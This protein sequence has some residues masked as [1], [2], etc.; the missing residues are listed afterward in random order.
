MDHSDFSIWQLPPYD[1]PVDLP[2]PA[3]DDRIVIFHNYAEQMFL[4]NFRNNDI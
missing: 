1:N 4:C 3:C 2:L